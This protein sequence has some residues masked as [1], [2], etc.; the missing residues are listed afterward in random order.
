[1]QRTSFATTLATLVALPRSGPAFGASCQKEGSFDAWLEG[2]AKQAAA[3]GVSKEAIQA[4][5]GNVRFDQGIV[6][7]DR[8]Q[9][10]FAQTFLE[11]SDR[12]V[13]G[14]P[15]RQQAPGTIA[16]NQE[17]LRRRSRSSTAFRR[18]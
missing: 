4:G 8:G 12:M 1:M 6:N 5:L 16:K 14:L 10:V 17:R 15:R 13:A 9:E 18:R 3:E 7:K 11:F 2:V